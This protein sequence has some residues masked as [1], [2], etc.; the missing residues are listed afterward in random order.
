MSR[1]EYR[2]DNEEDDAG[3]DAEVNVSVSDD[4]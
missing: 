2:T 1:E 4:E 3:S